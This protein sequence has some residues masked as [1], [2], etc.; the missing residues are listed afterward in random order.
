MTL[1]VTIFLPG[2]AYAS[3]EDDPTGWYNS[4]LQNIQMVSFEKLQSEE[5]EAKDAVTQ[6]DTWL[7]DKSFVNRDNT[8][9][10]KILTFRKNQ[11]DMIQAELAIR[12]SA[13]AS[14]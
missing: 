10:Q 11:L 13:T 2:F 7:A 5:K 14:T 8:T 12:S 4:S 1:L 9:N 3:M 6:M